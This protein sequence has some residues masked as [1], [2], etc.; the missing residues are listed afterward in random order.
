ME[1]FPSGLFP[2]AHAPRPLLV[3]RPRAWE[4]RTACRAGDRVW[5]SFPTPSHAPSR[6]AGSWRRGTG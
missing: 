2:I 1:L 4:S 3:T 5:Q 6:R